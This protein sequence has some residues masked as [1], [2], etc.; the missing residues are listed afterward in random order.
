MASIRK[1]I[2]MFSV[3]LPSISSEQPQFH[4]SHYF[5]GRFV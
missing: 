5:I 2:E 4:N 1:L 3:F